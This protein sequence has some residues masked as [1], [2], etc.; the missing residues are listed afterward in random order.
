LPESQP[1]PKNT[2][3][4]S[5]TSYVFKQQGQKVIETLK[6]TRKKEEH[7]TQEFNYI[8]KGE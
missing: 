8:G 3:I 1:T 5:Q 7:P 6:G 4:L 2:T